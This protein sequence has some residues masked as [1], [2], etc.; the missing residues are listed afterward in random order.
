[1]QV[2]DELRSE[3]DAEGEYDVD[4]GGAEDVEF[5]DQVSHGHCFG[6]SVMQ[7]QPHVVRGKRDAGRVRHFETLK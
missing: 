2:L 4:V 1:M 7:D 3:D 5:E 6:Y